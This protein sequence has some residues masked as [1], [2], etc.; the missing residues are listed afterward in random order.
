MYHFLFIG[1][2]AVGLSFEEWRGFCGHGVRRLSSN[3]DYSLRRRE[4]GQMPL[5]LCSGDILGS[6]DLV[7]QFL[8][9]L[10]GLHV[11]ALCLPLSSSHWAGPLC[12]DGFCSECGVMNAIESFTTRLAL[13][14]RDCCET[15]MMDMSMLASFCC[16]SVSIPH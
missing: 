9:H 8:Y 10:F 14:L 6:F 12:Y 1:Y 4:E 16:S 13:L 2:F 5:F 7:F 15:K 3:Y 11:F